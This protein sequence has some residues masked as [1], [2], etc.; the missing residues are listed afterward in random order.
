QGELDPREWGAPNVAVFATLSGESLAPLYRACDVLVL[1]S[2]GE[3]FPLV[4]QEAMASGLPVLCGRDTAQADPRA[5]PYLHGIPVDLDSPNQTARSFSEEISKLLARSA[6]ASE[7]QARSEFA[8][9]A[10]S[11]G[12]A[13]SE[14]VRLLAALTRRVSL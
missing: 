6:D 1:P 3:G 12:A 9:S 8:K 2:V 5:A 14:Y 7:R 11:W 13:A 4:V 10:Y